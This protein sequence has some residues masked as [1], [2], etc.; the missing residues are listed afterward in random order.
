MARQRL[1]PLSVTQA[2]AV[3]VYDLLPHHRDPFDRLIIAQAI[4]EEMA[5]LTV[6]RAFAKYPVEIVWCGT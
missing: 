1:L 6:D 4:A 3:K 2:H 5:I